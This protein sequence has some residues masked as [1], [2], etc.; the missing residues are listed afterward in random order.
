M[1]GQPEGTRG[2]RVQPLSLMSVYKPV[3]FVLFSMLFVAGIFAAEAATTEEDRSQAWKVRL[4]EACDRVQPA[5]VSGRVV[6]LD[7]NPVPE[8]DVMISW[9]RATFLIGVPEKPAD[10]WIKSDD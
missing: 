6:D 1:S 3:V 8:A 4:R 5:R 2:H 10:I 9:S 7:A